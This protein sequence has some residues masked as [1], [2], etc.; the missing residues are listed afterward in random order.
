MGVERA[1]AIT[2]RVVNVVPNI[3]IV[4]G[5]G[6]CIGRNMS[7]MM[8]KP[9]MRLAMNLRR[10]VF[11]SFCLRSLSSSTG[12]TGTVPEGVTTVTAGSKTGTRV[13]GGSAAADAGW[14]TTGDVL[15]IRDATESG[16]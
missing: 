10:I 4:G 6:H 1:N 11:S 13:R 3:S 2:K 16:S 9:D 5:Q 7:P 12:S 15:A 8:V 14:T